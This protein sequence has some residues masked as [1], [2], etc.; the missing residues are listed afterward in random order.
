[1]NLTYDL[2]SLKGLLAADTLC[3][4]PCGYVIEEIFTRFPSVTELL[5][6]TEQEL[7]EIKGIGKVKA[8]Q[9]ISA[10]QLARML[11]VRTTN[12]CVIRSPKDVWRLLAPEM[13]FLQKEHFTCLF[14]NTKITLWPKRRFRSAF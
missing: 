7:T 9:I 13:S 8:R 5:D 11:A 3:E 2:S 14:L 12:P 1:M 4:K 6:A 10:I